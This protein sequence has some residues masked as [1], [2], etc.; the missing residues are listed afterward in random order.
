MTTDFGLHCGRSVRMIA[1]EAKKGRILCSM[2]DSLASGE[3]AKEVDL[4]QLDA[5]LACST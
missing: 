2:E 3:T 5:A 1:F 4:D